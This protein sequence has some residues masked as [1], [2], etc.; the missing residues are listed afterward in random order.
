MFYYLETY[1]TKLGTN[2]NHKSLR[3]KVRTQAYIKNKKRELLH[4]A[5]YILF[6]KSRDFFPS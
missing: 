4:Q 3:E 5:G 6:A 1:L 2:K